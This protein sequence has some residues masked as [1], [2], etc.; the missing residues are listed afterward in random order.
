MAKLVVCVY[1]SCTHD[2]HLSFYI[3]RD[4]L[5]IDVFGFKALCNDFIH[6]FPTYFISPLRISGSAVESLFSQFKYSAGGKLD[7]ANYQT[8]QASFLVRQAVQEH[9]SSKGCRDSLIRVSAELPKRKQYN[10]KN[11]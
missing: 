10:L 8:A 1:Y 9:H 7:A 11:E 2:C 6:Q 3:A 4:L 5:R